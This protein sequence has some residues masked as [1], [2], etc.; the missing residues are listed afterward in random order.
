MTAFILAAFIAIGSILWFL[1]GDDVRSHQSVSGLVGGLLL[2][3]VIVGSHF[4]GW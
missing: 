2:A 3:G 1:S 4:I